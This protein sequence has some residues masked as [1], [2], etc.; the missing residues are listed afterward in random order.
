MSAVKNNKAALR[1][2]EQEGEDAIGSLLGGEGLTK[3]VT[4]EQK[5]EGGEGVSHVE[6]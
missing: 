3:K 5:L 1:I 6:I 2:R 4:F